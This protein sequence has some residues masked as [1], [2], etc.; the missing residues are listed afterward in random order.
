MTRKKDNLYELVHSLSPAEKRYF[1]LFVGADGKQGNK[2]LELFDLLAK[3]KAYEE[4]KLLRLPTYRGHANRLQV[5]KN[6]LFQ[7]ILKYLRS[8]RKNS[9]PEL[10]VLELLLDIQSLY[11]R[12][13]WPAARRLT[14]KAR[15]IA[16]ENDYYDL[17]FTIGE[18]E[19]RLVAVSADPQ[20][21]GDS[22][23]AI[24]DRET[25]VAQQLELNAFYFNRYKKMR[26][27]NLREGYIKRG[28]A[29]DE[30]MSCLK[31]PHLQEFSYAT[32]PTAQLYFY[33]CY[34]EYF[35]AM[36][37]HEYRYQINW[38]LMAHFAKHPVL[39][40]N[41]PETYLRSL[42]AYLLNLLDL[43]R[44]TAFNRDIEILGQLEL[45][46]YAH[47]LQR[48]R[49]FEYLHLRMYEHY[50]QGRFEEAVA[51]YVPQ[52]LAYYDQHDHQLIF[53]DELLLKLEV[54]WIY[55]GVGELEK[56]IE[57]VVPLEMQIDPKLFADSFT[58]HCIILMMVHYELGDAKTMRAVAERMR[59]FLQSRRKMSSPEAFIIDFFLSASEDLGNKS[60]QRELLQNFRSELAVLRRYLYV[61]PVYP[62]ENI[63]WWVYSRVSQRTLAEV[64]RD[65]HREVEGNREEFIRRA[66]IEFP[67][68]TD[69]ELPNFGEE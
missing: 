49:A 58:A 15:K 30:F 54:G 59:D 67:G 34:I 43:G 26:F 11:Q 8:N 50:A 33:L 10:E 55:I 22:Y 4:D 36:R 60:R 17:R 29:L 32:N 42:V 9:T 66:R 68:Y 48:L 12:R 19:R 64:V 25:Y 23:E 14:D 69:I 2:Y 13:L 46:A 53:L 61:V 16:E 1:K 7:L 63:I 31:H 20:H 38:R 21:Y 47:H 52:V 39:Q 57:W 56:A 27:I 37:D 51:E 44:W 62:I 65:R 28:L 45:P 40:R 24:L 18:W 41:H 6:Y 35:Y 5:A 3:Q